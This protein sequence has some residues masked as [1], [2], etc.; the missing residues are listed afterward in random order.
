MSRRVLAAFLAVALLASAAPTSA[1]GNDK[2]VLAY[3]YSLWDPGNF[4]I[5]TFT[6]EQAYNSDDTAVM[7]R[8]VREAR[9]AGVNGFV[10]SWL[11][12]GDRTDRNLAQ[13]LDI[14]QRAGVAMTVQ[15]DTPL[16]WGVDDT[17][18]QLQALYESHLNHPNV[19]RYRGR[20]VI[21]F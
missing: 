13:L 5:S 8:H 18:A 4:D 21:F 3:Y 12:N 16:F 7:E 20:P 19:L 2:V 11:G 14:G 17:I 10:V 1:Q 6:P 15:V 9:D